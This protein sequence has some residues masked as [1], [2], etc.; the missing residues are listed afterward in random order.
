MSSRRER[1]RKINQP[2]P[3]K[4]RQIAVKPRSE[5]RANTVRLDSNQPYMPSRA[6]GSVRTISPKTWKL[7]FLIVIVLLILL[8]LSPKPPTPP[9]DGGSSTTQS[10]SPL[11]LK[12]TQV[13]IPPIAN[14]TG[15]ELKNLLNT[16]K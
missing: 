7:I 16:Q 15:N 3:I 1:Q 8:F 14:P 4:D 6:S 9:G 5:R 13:S 10:L 11:D 2:T 12:S